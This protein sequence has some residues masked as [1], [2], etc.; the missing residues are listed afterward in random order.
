MTFRDNWSPF[1]HFR[2]AAEKGLALHQ[3][4]RRG[5]EGRAEDSPDH[6]GT[7]PFWGEA[8]HPVLPT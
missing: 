2:R 7:G 8:L 1:L 6:R 3:L 4:E 5:G